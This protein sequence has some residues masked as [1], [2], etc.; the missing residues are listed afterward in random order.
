MNDNLDLSF[1]CEPPELT[2]QIEIS[3][4]A[5]SPL[6]MV[7]QQPGYYFR[8]ALQPTTNMILGMI[9][10]LLGMHLDLSDRK[11]IIKNLTKKIK[12][13]KKEYSGYATHP[14]MNGKPENGRNGYISLLQFHTEIIPIT[15][16]DIKVSYDDLWS[17]QLRDSGINFIGGSRNYSSWLERIIT[18]SKTQDTSKPIN[19]KTKKH[20]PFI[21][22]GDRKEYQSFSMEEL[23]ELEE[24]LV[25]ANSLSPHFPQYYSSP[26]KRGYVI[27][28]NT[29]D[30]QIKTTNKLADLL[31]TALENP[32]A[33]LYLG[34]NDGWVDLKWKRI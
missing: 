30:Y 10:N 29:Y 14:W 11:A 8:S 33:P 15:I 26:K 2:C 13:N 34:S 25:K 28:D 1:Y 24:G 22:F 16:P 9:E 17:M 31:E 5:L 6:S 23:K 18:L 3:I 20:P 27:P 21:S 4:Q 12:K 32:A 7:D 19:K